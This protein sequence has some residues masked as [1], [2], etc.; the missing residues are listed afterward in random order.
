MEE[1]KSHVTNCTT[2]ISIT[3]KSVLKRQHIRKAQSLN[4]SSKNNN[5]TDTKLRPTLT[6]QSN[7]KNLFGVIHNLTVVGVGK[8]S[9]G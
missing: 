5:V 9:L 7:K 2:H 8:V 4:L 1:N 3:L 6:R